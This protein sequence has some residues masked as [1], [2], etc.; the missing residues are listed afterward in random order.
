LTEPQKF[1]KDIFNSNK[2]GIAKI[3]ERYCNS[4]KKETKT[5]IKL[6]EYSRYFGQN[7]Q[8]QISPTKEII[9][10]KL[11]P[12]FRGVVKLASLVA[13]E[14][15]QRMLFFQDP[16]D[17]EIERPE[18]YASLRNCNLHSRPLCINETARLWVEYE[19]KNKKNENNQQKNSNEPQSY[20][21]SKSPIPVLAFI[22]HDS[23]KPLMAK[24]V[25]KHRISLAELVKNK[26][27]EMI[28][29]SGTRSHVNKTLDMVDPD[30]LE[31]K[32]AGCGPE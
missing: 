8:H 7:N 3:L 23:Q 27:L 14:K 22:A 1:L 5:Y 15:V 12:K 2:G 21:D 17:L 4:N 31:I 25:I 24:F 6:E 16:K 9:I 28:A 32:A 26:K 10:Y 13:Q 18:N 11:G 19:N 29:T 20:Q 30:C